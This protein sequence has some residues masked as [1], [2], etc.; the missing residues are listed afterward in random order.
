MKREGTIERNETFFRL[1]TKHD[2]DAR[3][4][5]EI[6][7][8]VRPTYNL[9]RVRR[10]QPYSLYFDDDDQVRG[11][12]Y[13]VDD[14][15]VLVT[16]LSND[17]IEAELQPI[18]YTTKVMTVA[19]KIDSSLFSSVVELGESPELALRLAEIFA[20]E[21]DFSSDLRDGDQYRLL[22]EKQYLGEEFV[23]YGD[24]LVAEI[25]N[26]GLRFH[27]ALFE[28]RKTPRGYYTGGG[29]SLRKDFLKSP[30]RFTRISSKF[31][32][33]RFHPILKRYRPHYGI[34]YA[35]PYGTP[36]VTVGDGAVVAARRKGPNGKMVR[37]RHN[38]TYESY[39][40]HLSRY[41]PGIK[42]GARVVQGQVIGYVGSTGRSTGPHLDFRMSK[43]GRFINFLAFHPPRAKP[44]H[45]SDR[46]DFLHEF[47]ELVAQFD[48]G[49]LV[50]AGGS[51]DAGK[52]SKLN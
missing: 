34:D 51:K 1:L 16:K 3:Q 27:A 13:F 8:A 15:Q 48:N 7:A 5:Y 23:K 19:G 29:K 49:A 30:L 22:V 20:W 31:S 42:R 4:A 2:I 36:I 18:R 52:K 17:S 21:I 37:L 44:V 26:A 50:L 28:G 9:N 32:S 43:R 25:L 12:E 40:L 10:G 46:A 45:R 6:I 35:A 24:I 39:Y 33:R 38:S 14:E 11:F 41:G 47:K